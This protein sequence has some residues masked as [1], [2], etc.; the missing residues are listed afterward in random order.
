MARTEY[1]EPMEAR[2]VL[3]LGNFLTVSLLTAGT[4]YAFLTAYPALEGMRLDLGAV[5]AF[6][7]FASAVSAAAHT[8]RRYRWAA[9]AAAVIALWGF[10]A[11]ESLFA[12]LD[13]LGRVLGLLPA[14][15]AQARPPEKETVQAVLPLLCGAAAW[16][17]GWTAVRMRA[18]H[19]AALLAILPVL[20]AIAGGTLPSWGALLACFTGW[21]AVLL[22]S[23]YGRKDSGSLG[24]AL[25][26]SQ[27]GMLALVL[28]LVLALPMEGYRRPQ[29]ATDARTDLI[30]GA[31][32]QLSRFFGMDALEDS[33]LADLGL[34]LS[35]PEEDGGV[36]EHELPEFVP[37]EEAAAREN[38]AAVGPRR[39]RN[40]AVLAVRSTQQGGGRAYLRGA[41]FAVYTGGSWEAV[42]SQGDVP[43][44]AQPSRFPG[45]TA[46]EGAPEYD[47]TIRD[48]AFK[49]LRYYPYRPV[50]EGWL[51]ES[52]RLYL[53][54]EEED[55]SLIMNAV[56][57]NPGAEEYEVGYRPGGPEDGYVPLEGDLAEEER[58][59]RDFVYQACLDVPHDARQ[60]LEPLLGEVDRIAVPFDSA[61]PDRYQ[62]VLARAARTAALLSERATY[63]L[64]TPAMEEGGDFVAHFLEEGRGYCVHFAT[65]GALL[66]RMQGVP[67]RYVSGYVADM[68]Y[69]GVAQVMDSD[70][71]AWVEIY[72]DGYGWYP[73]EMTPGYSG[74]ASGVSL[75]GAPEEQEPAVPDEPEP[76]DA[77][78]EG[79]QP[80]EEA[81]GAAVP[82]GGGPEAD[83]GPVDAVFPLAL[84]ILGR[85]AAVALALGGIYG[86]A[87]L[88]RRRAREAGDANR[89][90]IAA[91]C[92]YRRLLGL[93]GVEDELL[94]ELG[95]RAKFSQHTLT[96]EERQAAWAR[97]DAASERAKA[98]MPKW[99]ARLFPL[100]RP[101]Y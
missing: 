42:A 59:Y 15:T 78:E 25:L 43:A 20:P 54:G 56:L 34:D 2:L 62:S 87:V 58:L 57:Y 19:T 85:A 101:L 86:L 55:E 40:R 92:R 66:L 81:P 48:L 68:D 37:V 9:L 16:I 76:E 67:A 97:L 99:Q 41:A 8:S 3:L 69:R 47:M 7:L 65:A 51:D 60:V 79:G 29:W 45:Q 93:G 1:P 21:G 52:G 26:L 100:V 38:L 84:R 75:A 63:D 94:E 11:R 80:E 22:T 77:P 88:V 49:G 98:R 5:M 72:L 36:S 23:L 30:R 83:G 89:S 82:P 4:A 44:A 10:F 90:V 27:G 50:G 28:A 6:C 74:G 96:R 31:N 24:R 46:P 61:M 91:Y 95:R 17:F 32:R 18:W 35:V 13:W 53:Y 14:Y 71:H 70:A 12:V 64:D 39:Y 73:V 33:F